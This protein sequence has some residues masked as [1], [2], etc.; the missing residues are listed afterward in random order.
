M[1]KNKGPHINPSKCLQDLPLSDITSSLNQLQNGASVPTEE[2]RALRYK[3]RLAEARTE[4]NEDDDRQRQQP[5]GPKGHRGDRGQG[6]TLRLRME[7]VEIFRHF[8]KKTDTN[9][10]SNNFGEF[11]DIPI[12]RQSIAQWNKD[13]NKIKFDVAHGR[14]DKRALS[15]NPDDL[16]RHILDKTV[17][18]WLREVRKN[19]G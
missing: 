2:A 9:V 1:P 11:M 14:G 17:F 19:N 18:E 4:T 15:R 5:V 7:M 13:F 3:A 12:K 8:S 10:T 16:I 6:F